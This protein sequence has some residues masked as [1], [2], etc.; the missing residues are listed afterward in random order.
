MSLPPWLPQGVL[1]DRQSTTDVG[2]NLARRFGI[3]QPPGARWEGSGAHIQALYCLTSVLAAPLE[4]F[5]AFR[6]TLPDRG[7][8]A[9]S[10]SIS[11]LG[12]WRQCF[13][14]A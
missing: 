12:R 6:P 5:F 1:K 13:S 11:A 7:R 9:H 3:V 2:P 4:R 8:Y 14:N 10:G